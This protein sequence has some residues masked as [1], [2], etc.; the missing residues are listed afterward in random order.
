MIIN[1]SCSKKKIIVAFLLIAAIVAGLILDT[2]L[3]L[4]YAEKRV[5][6][7]NENI[8]LYD[9]LI[10]SETEWLTTTPLSNG[11]LAFYPV[12]DGNAYLN[13]YFS[14]YTALALIRGNNS[15]SIAQIVK[16]YLTW[17]FEHLNSKEADENGLYYTI[18]DYTAEVKNGEVI[19]ESTKKDYD[20]ADSYA[21]YF[22]YVLWE[23]YEQTGDADFLTEHFTE[24]SGITKMLLSLQ[25]PN[26]LTVASPDYPVCYL[27]D[28]C[29]VYAG[30]NGALNLYKK[31]LVPYCEKNN[32]AMLQTAKSLVQDLKVSRIALSAG[33]EDT[34]WNEAGAYY[35]SSVQGE[36]A[37]AQFS[38]NELYPSASAQLSSFHHGVIATKSCRAVSLYKQFCNHY[39][40]QDMEN[41][42]D[43][44]ADFY[45][46]GIAYCAALM[47][48]YDR[49]NQYLAMYVWFTAEGHPH[50][51]YN[52]DAGLVVLACKQA[53][54]A[55]QNEA[56]K[57]DPFKLFH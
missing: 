46:S 34:L 20:S 40:W 4:A 53:K 1:K 42:R 11:A 44:N 22:L 37:Y 6:K 8:A 27:M 41:F 30:L 5:A 10:D 28:N 2:L 12:E 19:S 48:D 31:L 25:Q 32:T 18:Y 49:L 35:E 33:I 14:D 24:I 17:H 47:K 39:N 29:E 13:P 43:G 21:G 54:T 51:A 23:Y 15:E 26:G 3:Y 55:C 9:S 16:N 56:D 52:A 38:W 57:I 36:D 50:P 45:G 7:L